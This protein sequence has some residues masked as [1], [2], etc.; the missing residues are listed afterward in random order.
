LISPFDSSA[1][2]TSLIA[3]GD[4]YARLAS[5]A[6]ESSPRRPSTL[7]VVYW[8]TVRPKI[9]TRSLIDLRIARSSRAT[10]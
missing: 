3:C 7:R 5:C 1:S 8:S 6:F 2:I 4:M 10:T 9:E